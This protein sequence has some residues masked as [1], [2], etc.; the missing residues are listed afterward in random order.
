MLANRDAIDDVLR[1]GTPAFEALVRGRTIVHMGTTAPEYSQE[2]EADILAAGGAYVEAPVSG[3]RKP[4]ENA[5]LVGMLAGNPDSVERVRAFIAPTCRQQFVCGA[6]PSALRMKL[7]V[8][9]YL[10]TM[11][12]ALVESFHFAQEHGLDLQQFREILDSGPMSSSVSKMKLEKLVAGNFEVQA[13][14]D[15][16]LM[17]SNLV[18]Q[19]ARKAHVASPLLDES[20]ALFQLTS[21]LGHGGEDMAAVLF[22]IADR[23]ARVRGG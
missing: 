23:T 19:A 9:L 20:R 7:S 11:V 17:N 18:A 8:N 6:V 1:R 3:S 4:A 15:D 12:A 2:L 10:I 13:A 16:V 5:Q 21:D 22:A 14:I